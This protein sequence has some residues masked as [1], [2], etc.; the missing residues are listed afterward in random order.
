MLQNNLGRY[1]AIVSVV[2]L[3]AAGFLYTAGLFGS[4]DVTAQIR[5]VTSNPNSP[6]QGYLCEWRV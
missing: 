2:G 5:S 3:L 4:K 1:L 6:C